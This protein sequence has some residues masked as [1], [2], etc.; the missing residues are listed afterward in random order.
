MRTLSQADILPIE[1]FVGDRRKRESRILEVKAARRLL[2]SPELLLVFENRDTAWWQVQEMCRVE[3]IR[4][5]EAVQHE[6]DTYNALIPGRGELSA[7]LL[8]GYEDPRERD[9][10]LREL[11][12]LHQ[13][14]FLVLG[15]T[16]IPF[17]F[18]EAQFEETRVSS[19][20]FVKLALGDHE[21]AFRNFA[22]PAAV[23]VDHPALSSTVKLSP[24]VRG[25]L[26]E[27]LDSE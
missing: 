18:D 20:Q 9:R 2:V 12:G 26:I 19:V 1:Q 27:D 23:V 10:R 21:A 17:A 15:D 4:A 25:A 6:I 16:R 14:L 13:H 22:V 11:V 8:I 24:V 5:P 3:G 7:T